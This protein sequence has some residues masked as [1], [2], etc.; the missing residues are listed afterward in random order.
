MSADEQPDRRPR[1]NRIIAEP[2]T[3]DTC[4]RDY[5]AGAADRATS[6][7]QQARAERRS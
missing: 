1:E 3:P 4:R 6:A 7:K 2:A 5:D